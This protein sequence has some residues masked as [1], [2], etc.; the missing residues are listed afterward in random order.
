MCGGGGPQQVSFI[1]FKGINSG[2]IFVKRPANITELLSSI[3][4]KI[5]KQLRAYTPE[6]LDDTIIN[7]LKEVPNTNEEQVLTVMQR[8]TQWANYGCLPVIGNN[9]VALNAKYITNN[10]NLNRVFNYLQTSKKLIDL[11]RLSDS[12]VTFV[13]EGDLSNILSKRQEAKTFINLEGFDA[14]VNIFTDDN[15]LQECTINTLFKIH[16]LLREKQDKNFHNGLSY[17]LNNEIITKMSRLGHNVQTL[18]INNPP[19]KESILSQMSP[20]GPKSPEDIRLTL[21]KIAKYYIREDN[22]KYSELLTNIADY[23]DLKLNIFSKQRLIENLQLLKIKIDKF[24]KEKNIPDEV[25]YYVIPN[26]L[27][28]NKSFGLLTEMFARNNNIPPEK[29]I[30][31]D[32]MTDLNFLPEKSTFIIIDDFVGTG[33]SMSNVGDYM[34]DR[35]QLKKDRHILFCPVTAY[36]EG[37]DHINASIEVAQRKDYDFL[38]TLDENIQKLPHD[39]RNIRL[40][41]YFLYDDIGKEVFGYEGYKNEYN[42]FS[43][44]IVFPYM[45]PDNNSDL[46]S[47][48][49]HLFFTNSNAIKQKHIDFF[50][51]F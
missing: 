18:Q 38:I 33:D 49:T 20:I 29:I 45:T 48:I 9:I 26:E 27:G 24:L 4:T 37:I 31:V 12:V 6:Q 28:E 16:N 50:K 1:N 47:M 36:E 51:V 43:G 19:T 44:C 30:R 13:T 10:T 22:S 11:D 3:E 34:F 2:D 23:F 25:T 8:L 21:E 17:V 35:F 40:D 42:S 46:A 7:V 14:G 15:K 32:N 5:K 41:N 39:K